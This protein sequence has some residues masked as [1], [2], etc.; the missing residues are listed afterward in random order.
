MVAITK[1]LCFSFIILASF[2][3]LFSV[4]DAWYFNVGGNGVW[5]VNPR[6]SYNT[7][8]EKNRFQVNDTLYFKFEKESDSV[9]EVMDVDYNGC[10]VG[11]P[12]Q[13]FVNGDALVTLNRTGPFYFISGNQ[14]HCLKGQKLVVVV[15]SVRNHQ[16]VP[17]SPAKAPMSHSPV[18]PA[19]APKSHSP[20][21]P[22]KAPKSHSP[23]SPISPAKAPTTDQPPKSTSPVSPISPAKAPST[24]K[25]PKSHS[26]ASPAKA[27]S[28]AK[29]PKSHS[30]VSPISPAIAPL[31]AQSPK[32]PSPVS[33]VNPPSK[34][35]PPKSSVSHAPAVSPSHAPKSPSPSTS[36]PVNSPTSSPSPDES[37][38]FPTPEQSSPSPSESTPSS[39]NVTAPA[40]SPKNAAV[41]AVAS[42]MTSVLSVVFTFLMFG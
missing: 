12:L 33:P 4:A 17:I 31:T 8:A 24:A 20:V 9:Q 14:D 21:S 23:V 1:S 36:S 26:P 32:S 39:A 27:P 22:A 30:P 10:N 19:K 42:V 2:A 5:A 15:L 3:T 6:L 40:P 25:P 38:D 11:N 7:W 41:V 37:P 18:S 28:T 13:N 35:Q 34:S 16:T 29:P